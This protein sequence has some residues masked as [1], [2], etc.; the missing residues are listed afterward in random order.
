MTPP[1]VSDG[2]FARALGAFR[3]AVGAQWVFTGEDADLY[4]DAY[5]PLWG[6][7]GERRASAAVAPDRVE[8]VQQIV[9]IASAYRIPLYTISTGRNLAYGGSAPVYSG[10][11]VLDLKRMNRILEVSERNAYAL[12]E[13]GVSYFDLYRYIRERNL[14]LW[15]D[16][17]DPGWGSPVGNALDHGAGYTPLPFRDH[18]DAHCGMEVVL[19]SGEIVR[20]GM[21]ALPGARTWQQFK[22]GIGPYLDGIF[23]QSNFGVVTKMGFWLYPQPEA[24]RAG[25][26]RVP[27][28][29]DIIALVD[30]LADLMYSGIVNCHLGIASPIFNGPP[31]AERDALIARPDGG[32]AADWDRYAAAR[33]RHFW[34]TELH[35]YGPAKLLDAQWSYVKERFAAIPAARFSD[36]PS[37]RFPLSDDEI[38]KI[39]DRVSLSIPSLGIY[40]GLLAG[41]GE[42]PTTGHMDFSPILPMS[43]EAILEAHRV[44]THALR[45]GDIAP[46]YGVVQSFHWRSFIL[47]YGFPVTHDAETNRKVR[48]TYAR[49]IELAAQ[50]GWG[51]YRTHAAFQDTAVETYSFD[52]HAL[53][54]LHETLKDA[55]DPMGI[56]SAG[57]YGIWP[58]HLREKKA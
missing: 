54:R 8:Q 14:K 46:Q 9:R 35:F 45:A 1:G 20:T 27:R 7:P 33:G 22:Y 43:G 11:V 40:A 57:R 29:D 5:S 19:A 25:T 18:F 6:E 17:P 34:E 24:F 58:E 15:I 3:E 26:V 4:R 44:F 50:H 21:G 53:H 42:P 39:G 48:A 30:I 12:V 41:S 37:Y 23:S 55:I 16:T 47:F 56:L 36:G 13:P 38:A 52:D 49:M 31:D 32:G 51:V 28:H 10:S 2:D